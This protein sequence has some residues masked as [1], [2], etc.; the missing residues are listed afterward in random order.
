MANEPQRV[1]HIL[2]DVTDAIDTCNEWEQSFVRSVEEQFRKKGE[3]TDG[4][5][6]KLEQIW[7]KRCQ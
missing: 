2:E 5:Y 7:E 4:Q 6:D 1:K 3:L